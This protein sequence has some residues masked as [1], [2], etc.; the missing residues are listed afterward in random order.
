MT[1]FCALHC[2]SEYS[3]LDGLVRR[4]R[5]IDVSIE[6]GWPAACITDHG[7]LS[8]MLSFYH[9][10][11]E[12]GIKP[13]IGVEAY[14]ANGS[15]KEKNGSFKKGDER[16]YS[17]ITLLAKNIQGYKNLCRMSTEA[18]ETGFYYKPRIDYE[19]LDEYGDGIIVLSGCLASEIDKAILDNNSEKLN[20]VIE[21]YKHRFGE[22]FYLEFMYTGAK[23]EEGQE[24]PQ[25]TVNKKLAT[26]CKLYNIKPVIT[27]DCHYV[28]DSDFP[29][30]EITLAMSMR[31]T[32]SDPG[33][34]R[35][36]R[37]YHLKD[38]PELK[39]AA[40]LGHIPDAAFGTVG[41]IIDKVQDYEL[42]KYDGYF[43]FG[44][45][46]DGDAREILIDKCHVALSKL[47]I[48][49]IDTYQKRLEHELVVINGLDYAA[50]FLTLEKIISTARERGIMVGPCRGSAGGSLV[51]YLLKITRV[52]PIKYGLIFERFLNAE[53]SEHDGIIKVKSSRISPP[54]IDVDFEQARRQDVLDIA[55]E[56]HPDIKVY[57]IGTFTQAKAKAIMGDVAVALGI[58][59]SDAIALTKRLHDKDPDISFVDLLEKHPEVKDAMNAIDTRWYK[60]CSEADTLP[61]SI[62]CH[63]SGIIL[64]QIDITDIVPL[65]HTGKQSETNTTGSKKHTLVTCYDMNECDRLGLLKMDFLGLRTLDVIK[66]AIGMIKERHGVDIDPWDLDYEDPKVYDMLC[67]GNTDGVFQAESDS[68]KQAFIKLKPD[69]FDLLT[70]INAIT[71][72]GCTDSGTDKIFIERRHGRENVWYYCPDVEELL[73]PTYGIM[74]YQEQIMGVAKIMAGYTDSEADDLRRGIGKKI[75]EYV[76]AHEGK[77]KA[78]CIANDHPQQLADL[79]WDHIKAAARYSWNKSH[80]VGYSQITYATAWLKCYYKEELWAATLST[81]TGDSEKSA[82]YINCAKMDGVKIGYPDINKSGCGFGLDG[83]RLIFGLDSVIG[84]GP[85]GVEAILREQAKGPF[86]SYAEFALRLKPKEVNKK[87]RLTLIKAGAFDGLYNLQTEF[88]R[89]ALIKA[90]E[91]S[92]YITKYAALPIS[93]EAQY[94]SSLSGIEYCSDGDLMKHELDAFGSTIKMS[95]FD[96]FTDKFGIPLNKLV[97]LLNLSSITQLEMDDYFTSLVYV[98]TTTYKTSKAGN[99]YCVLNVTDIFNVTTNFTLWPSYT[100]DV[101]A[102]GG[103]INKYI[104]VRGQFKD[105]GYAIFEIVGSDDTDFELYFDFTKLASIPF[106]LS[107]QGLVNNATE[108]IFTRNQLYEYADTVLEWVFGEPFAIKPVNSSIYIDGK[109]K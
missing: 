30:H 15:R 75:K 62:G 14:L 23:G 21:F 66:S 33:R 4:D 71:R 27:G 89:Y 103:L 63:A 19:L 70:A 8:Q 85:K 67:R 34:M 45:L 28:D 22:D 77:F 79:V 80:A 96:A 108:F 105:S 94:L 54:D 6:R 100:D 29:L 84:I 88:I 44:W 106:R 40:K 109:K 25:I 48:D 57:H 10:A 13:I 9:G 32:L 3:L 5:L 104:F 72:P 18:S 52:D 7:N 1:K 82:Q 55:R 60:F 98:N 58:S 51:S 86:K 47:K 61:K 93:E 17:H 76:D 97:K 24:E 69:S 31:K 95:I 2:H 36:E 65:I 35:F 99:R 73:S 20:K 91:D 92:K 37:S 16:P 81:W 50:Y 68:F 83:D 46:W 11:K 38:I 101:A 53:V 107:L 56:L 74:L 41:E 49:D 12:H 102:N 26:L 42:G 59:R 90:Y 43:K 39:V 87:M 64:S 78:G